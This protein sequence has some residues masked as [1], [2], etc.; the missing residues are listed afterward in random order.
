MPIYEFYCEDCH[1]IYSFFSRR[2]NTEKHPGCPDCSRS[3]LT[4]Q[5]S[6]FSSPRSGDDRAD[7]P[8][9]DLDQAGLERAMASMSQDLVGLD[10]ENPR[11]AASVMRRLFDA[12]GLRIGATM[13]EAIERLE[14]GE[15]PDRIEAEL[16]KALQ[17]GDLFQTT[18]RQLIHDIRRK[19][20]PP[21]V[22][23]T[24]YELD[25]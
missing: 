25:A 18:P 14:A 12:S 17:D 9:A 21:R 8:P 13:D 15:D 11:Q 2:V 7:E 20:L 3:A 19:H 6:M 22:D 24:L 5:V 10:E 23:E 4:R 16:G 1:T